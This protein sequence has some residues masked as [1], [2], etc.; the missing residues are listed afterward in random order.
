[1]SNHKTPRPQ[2]MWGYYNYTRLHG[3][4][5]THRQAV[6]TVEEQCLEPWS[7]ARKYMQIRKVIVMP[8]PDKEG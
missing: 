5:H 4:A 2:L 7:K 3:V 1:M 8:V 6:N